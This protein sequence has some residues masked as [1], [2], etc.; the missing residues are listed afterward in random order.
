MPTRS[1]ASITR[2]LRS[3]AGILL[4][5]GQRQFDIL[6]DREIADQIETLE[7]EPDF[8]VANARALREI[9]ILDRLPIQLIAPAGRRIEQA[10]DR[11]QR[12]FPAA[13]RP[14]HGDIFAFIDRQVNAGERVRFDLIGVEDFGQILNLDERLSCFSHCCFPRFALA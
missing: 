4:A 9:E 3:A 6:I 14:R 13:R 7:D 1:S 12:R 8:L 11:E 10:D 2:F 5:V